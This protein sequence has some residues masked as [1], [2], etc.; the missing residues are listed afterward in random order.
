[1]LL[2]FKLQQNDD[3]SNIKTYV[4]EDGLLHFIDK[5]G[6]DTALNF[7]KGINITSIQVKTRLLTPTYSWRDW[8]VDLYING[9]LVG[10]YNKSIYRAATIEYSAEGETISTIVNPGIMINYTP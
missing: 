4:G 6:A 1:M 10:S 9:S 3:T 2:L 5:A 7:N 8:Y